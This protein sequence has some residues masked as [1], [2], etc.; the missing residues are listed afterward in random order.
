MM[1][2][3]I[4][5]FV[6]L[7]LAVLLP[8]F[9]QDAPAGFGV[10][11]KF[12]LF[13]SGNFAELR[14]N[15]FHAGLDF[16][17]QGVSGKPIYAIADGYIARAKVSPGGYGRALYVVHPGGYMTVY[18]HLHRFPLAVDSVV[19]ATQY[20][21]EEFAVDISFP[22]DSLVVKRG[23]VLAWAGN[24]GYS[25]GPHLHFELR[26]SCGE[27]LYNPMS[28]YKDKISDTRKPVTRAVA[29]YPCEGRGVVCGQSSPV[30]RSLSGGLSLDTLPAWGRVGF[31]IDALDYMDGTTNKYGVYEI[32]L[33]VDDNLMFT[34]CMDSYSFS[35]DR[36]INAWAAPEGKGLFMRS[37]LLDNNPLGMLSAGGS[38]GWVDI[39]EERLYK[40][41]YRL[42]D[43][44]GNESRL[45]FFVVGQP[46]A[47]PAAPEKNA[48]W[49]S[50]NRIY[51]GGMSLEI[52]RGALFENASLALDVDNSAPSPV[53]NIG[54][55]RYPLWKKARITLPVPEH[56]QPL[57]DKCYIK[58]ITAKGGTS[59]GGQVH[60]CDISAGI[61][62]LGSYVVAVDTVPPV[63]RPVNEKQWAQAGRVVLKLSD[64]HTAISSFK[65]Y[66][67]GKFVLFEYSSK[68]SE[69]VCDVKRE[70]VKPGKRVF[71]I[72]ATDSVGNEAV[73]EKTINIR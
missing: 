48:L 64:K 26:S 71:K 66:V 68:N 34:S 8:A 30:V 38:G 25:F 70:K 45:S 40:V 41:E 65:G 12:P 59:V 36:L 51:C 37:F 54:G 55:E 56:L 31:G 20:K 11:F 15:H 21:N 28:L 73:Y 10:P 57:S 14:S 43:Y 63:I 4:Y 17:T 16:K 24:T 33:Y 9:A 58:R 23:D 3:T 22:V 32:E 5:T 18:G 39:S 19:R 62:V 27:V 72:V 47:I 49:Y 2:K 29:V 61:Y 67:D 46:S 7:L 13:L 60:G 69:L 6:T 52:P 53:Y 1:R 35:E 50:D 44:H 42:R